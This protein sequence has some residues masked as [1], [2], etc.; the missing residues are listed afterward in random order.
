MR[1]LTLADALAERGAECRFVTSAGEGNLVSVIRERGHAVS[2]LAPGPAQRAQVHRPATPAHSEWLGRD[3]E[4]DAEETSAVLQSEGADLLLVDHYAIDFRWEQRLR[5]SCPQLMVIDDL[6][7]R[8]HACDVLLDQNVGR[9]RADYEHLVPAEC[10]I[11]AGPRYALLR[12]EFAAQRPAALARRAGRAEL[13][14]LLVTL[15]GVDKDNATGTVLDALAACKLPRD[16]RITVVMGPHAPWIASVKA[17][18]AAMS[19][20][21]EVLSGVANMAAIMADS[22]LAIGAVGGTAL[23]RCCLGLP[24]LALV[25]AENQR[26]GALA[27][28]AVGAAQ[29]V[30]GGETLQEDL[31]SKLA[32]LQANGRLAAMSQAS[33]AVADGTGAAAVRE[34]L[35]S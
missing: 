24:T 19:R 8:Q 16:C 1:C 28:E 7:D 11:L 22:D 34:A 25:I 9:S 20:P 12:P 13:R 29:I 18:A 21:V 6:A 35:F 15:G 30:A 10:R 5:G 2:V 32:A 17:Q 26:P 31:C 27:L 14:H 23:E 3:W 4:T 33:A